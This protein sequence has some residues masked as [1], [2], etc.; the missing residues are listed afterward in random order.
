MMWKLWFV[1]PCPPPL[2]PRTLSN[3][4]VICSLFWYARVTYYHVNIT[5]S[6]LP[7]TAIPT[8]LP[9]HPSSTIEY[10]F[11]QQQR[12]FSKASKHVTPHLCQNKGFNWARMGAGG[13]DQIPSLE[14]LLKHLFSLW[15]IVKN[16][17]QIIKYLKYFYFLHK[18][19]I[20]PGQSQGLLY[21]QSLK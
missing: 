10:I 2:P 14:Q 7:P 6:P 16:W 12:F 17:T 5:F 9:P 20:R 1:L 3:R 19:V 11:I 4:K 15:V 18:I 8:I 13:G 21:K